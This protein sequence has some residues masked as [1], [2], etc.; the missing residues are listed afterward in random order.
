MGEPARRLPTY[1]D[2]VNAP[3]GVTAEILAGELVL[4]PR[5]AVSHSRV[6][7]GLGADLE[8]FARGSGGP[9]GWWFLREL[10]LHLGAQDPKSVVVVPDL[11]G[12]RRDHMPVLLDAPAITLPPDWVCEVLSPGPVN[13]RRDRV[14]KP[15]VYAAAGVP[16]LWYIDPVEHLLEVRKLQ[17]TVYAVIQTFVGEDRVRAEPFDAIELDMAN[18][19]LPPATP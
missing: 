13:T 1:D 19:W 5:P 11:A 16:Y 17:G 18:W 8:L 6:E 9:R 14:L 7:G 10:E 12:W 15:I 3:D 4:S 2:V